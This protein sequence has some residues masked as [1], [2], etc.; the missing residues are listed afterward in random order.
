[1]LAD[2]NCKGHL[3]LLLSLFQQHWRQEVWEFLGLAQVSFADLGL[4]PD[5][6][7]REMWAACQ[8]AYV[9]LLT[10]NRNDEGLNRSNPP[11]STITHLRVCPYSPL[12][13]ISAC[14]EIGSTPKR[15]PIGCSKLYLT[16]TVIAVRVGS[17]YPSTA[18]NYQWHKVFGYFDRT[19]SRR[20]HYRMAV[21]YA[22][23]LG[24]ATKSPVCLSVHGETIFWGERGDH[25]C[26]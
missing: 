13:M 22:A 18:C 10:A 8:H 16:L 5:A 24:P 12:P 21:R 26:S 4:P 6:S 23:T 25:P 19:G 20:A 7:D 3:A 11:S 15:L 1:M 2:A 17:T 14:C 9:V